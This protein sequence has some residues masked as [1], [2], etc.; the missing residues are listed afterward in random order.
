MMTT[1][2]PNDKKPQTHY[3]MEDVPNMKDPAVALDMWRSQVAGLVPLAQIEAEVQE[4]ERILTKAHKFAEKK[5]IEPLKADVEAVWQKVVALHETVTRYDATLAGASV[6]V[7]AIDAQRR[8]ALNEI[9]EVIGALRRHGA[10]E[11]VTDKVNAGQMKLAKAI[12]EV[13]EQTIDDAIEQES[14]FLYEVAYENVQMDADENLINELYF[15]A[16]PLVGEAIAE[17]SSYRFRDYVLCNVGMSEATREIF[18][19]FLRALAYDAEREQDGSLSDD[20]E[21]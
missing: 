1:H 21:S 14:E 13:I 19:S 5:G 8:E 3:D 16:H 12:D 20:E 2:D 9:G 7:D 6:A 10:G 4:A 15:R 17:T 18:I 11:Y